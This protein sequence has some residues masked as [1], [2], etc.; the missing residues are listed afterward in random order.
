MKKSTRFAVALV[1]GAAVA[2]GSIS[3]VQAQPVNQSSDPA[4]AVNSLVED[5][6]N[7]IDRAVADAVR[8]IIAMVP[9]AEPL[10]APLLK[11]VAQPEPVIRVTDEQLINEVNAARAFYDNR[12][13]GG[14][15]GPL[16]VNAELTASARQVAQDLADKN[17]VVQMGNS[18][19]VEDG[20]AYYAHTYVPG[21]EPTVGEFG[22]QEHF[23]RQPFVMKV[24]EATL[25]SHYLLGI[26]KTIG[27]A[28]V[29][30]DGRIYTVM[31]LG[32]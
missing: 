13:S 5:V 2:T 16:T 6:Q 15:P 19:I 29:E 10:L 20:V 23:P 22:N 25:S 11:P 28:Q 18:L 12:E 27:V 26:Y 7:Q 8:S 9:Q 24:R 32:G 21:E 1:A 14:A 31:A 30:K 4:V 17:F 3:P